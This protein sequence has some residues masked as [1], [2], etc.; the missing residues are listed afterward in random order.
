MSGSRIHL[1][2]TLPDAPAGQT[3]LAHGGPCSGIFV[4]VFGRKRLVTGGFHKLR[5]RGAGTQRHSPPKS[6]LSSAPLLARGCWCQAM[7]SALLSDRCTTSPRSTPPTCRCPS[8]PL[9]QNEI[10]DVLT[11]T[12]ILPFQETSH[13]L[14]PQVAPAWKAGAAIPLRSGGLGLG[15]FVCQGIVQGGQGWIKYPPGIHGYPPDIRL[16]IS[17]FT[18]DQQDVHTG[19]STRD[20]ALSIAGKSWIFPCVPPKKFY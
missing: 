19:R 10:N 2:H 14:P 3:V 1:C 18:A 7:L 5:P 16:G 17:T 11:S 9:S 6:T 4:Q 13:P 12:P 15:A 20:L 8:P